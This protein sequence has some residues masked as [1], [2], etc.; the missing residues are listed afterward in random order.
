MP[1]PTPTALAVTSHPS[2]APVALVASSGSVPGPGVT[3]PAAGPVLHLAATSAQVAPGE[4]SIVNV[5]GDSGLE[6][7]GAL[8]VTVE[9]DP[10]VAEV[11][12][13]VPGPWRNAEGAEAIR[14]D[15]DRTAG[16]ARLH[17]VRITGSA[18]LPAGVLAKLAVRGLTPGTT[19]MRAT[20][21]SA[22]T[23]SGAAPAPRVE[24]AS[25]TVKSV[26]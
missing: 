11:T 7:L 22:A 14:F 3:T 25:L 4:V 21:G 6:A 19:L 26:S 18:G 1:A 20:A 23:P 5:T 8:E 16:R 13:V 17:F 2:P 9:W 15:S 12:G 10:A 24:A